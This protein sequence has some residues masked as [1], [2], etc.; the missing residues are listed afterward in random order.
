MREGLSLRPPA[1]PT[2][3]RNASPQTPTST[4]TP[5]FG[6]AMK[7]QYVSHS[8][9]LP[10][11]TNSTRSSLSA[12]AHAH[13]HAGAAKE[14]TGT[15]TSS[16]KPPA[17]SSSLSNSILPRMSDP[18]PLFSSSTP[19][20]ESPQPMDTSRAAP[21]TGPQAVMAKDGS[22][23]TASPY[24][25]RS[26]NRNGASRPNYAE[27]KDLDADYDNYRDGALAKA[28]TR[29]A[30]ITN[31]PSAATQQPP[32]PP[33][34]GSGSARKPLVSS[35]TDDSKQPSG[36]HHQNSTTK[37]QSAPHAPPPAAS[38]SVATVTIVNAPSKSKKRKADHA[39]SSS[40]SQTPLSTGVQ[41][42]H[43]GVASNGNG[44][45]HAHGQNAGSGGGSGKRAGGGYGESNLLTFEASGALL[46]NGKMVAD[47]G[48][49]L[50]VNGEYCPFSFFFCGGRASADLCADHVYLI[51][52]PPG[53]PYYLGRIMEFLH[54]ASDDSK[55]I[56]ALR[57]NWYYR[58]KDIGKK[59]QDTRLVFATMHSDISPLTS[60][61][62]KC[63]IRHKAEIP[64]MAAYKRA[65]DNFWYERLYD[66][67]I[68]KNY[69]VIPT[70][71]IINVP[72]HVKRVLDE[73]WKFILV[74]QGRGKEL[75]SAVKTCKR[76][77]GYCARYVFSPL[78]LI[79][80]A[81]TVRAAAQDGLGAWTGGTRVL[82]H[83][84]ATIRSIVPCANRRTT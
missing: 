21:P 66:R 37:D 51:C 65:P 54:S 64:D 18:S 30:S 35:S 9:D 1:V 7:S 63:Q 78:L 52:E 81:R 44:A 38:S 31:L 23:D 12:N 22:G 33:R 10:P 84:P 73:R 55:P 6:V 62:G 5:N 58:P 15:T 74:E 68:Q 40:G 50:E 41:R 42:R 39:P 19:Y 71:Q 29:Q 70:A 46:K 83:G 26:R 45:S 75:T 59:V 8:E 60:L 27:D 67:Y 17:S 79:S 32:A 43:G 80:F 47:D 3:A 69:E 72:E 76:C 77:V 48:T 57:I 13:A 25:T 61:R 16:S 20:S 82:T 2:N 36:S 11:F 34:S 24:G 14:G 28:V 49:V 56:E 53:E 4:L